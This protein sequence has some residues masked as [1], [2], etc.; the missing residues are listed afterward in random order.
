[1][2]AVSASE[3]VSS[4]RD[5]S[6]GIVRRSTRLVLGVAALGFIAVACAPNASQDSLKPAGPYAEKIDHL[7]VPVFWFAVVP[8][9]ILV[10]GMLVWISL[11]YRHRK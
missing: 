8:I 3:R 11:R 9:F 1:V 6:R 5:R 7:F 2:R 10:E 4:E